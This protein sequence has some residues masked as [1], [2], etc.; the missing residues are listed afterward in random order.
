MG[1][2]DDLEQEA[3]RRKAT[4]GDAERVKLER[5]EAFKT[6]LE[7]GLQA[8]HE[9]L[10][11]L[12]AN[13]SFLKPKTQVRFDF[14]GYGTVVAN[15]EH[16][17]DLRANTI[18]PLSKE[19]VLLFSA[20]V[21]TDECPV[22]QVNSPAKIRTLNSFFQKARLSGIAEFKKDESGEVTQA[23]FRARG[24]VTLN[25]TVAADAESGVAR[26]SFTNFDTLGTVT[27]S[28]AP[29]HFDEKLFDEVGRF[30]ARE[31]NTL[32]RE[33]LPEDF[34]KQLAQK[35]QQEQLKRKWESKIA[36]QQAQDMERAQRA[37]REQSL[38]GKIDRA[39]AGV[40]EKAPS[41]LDKVK[42]LFNKKS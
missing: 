40:A 38:K 7:P 30:I 35:V 34:R 31:T 22:V 42:G 32:F 18:T 8:F 33:Q 10:A 17:Y 9:Y 29:Q 37:Q 20:S 15:I 41:I 11:K 1:L 19:V 2:L 39:V 23:T 27:K 28:A 25:V 12:T 24:K 6:R 26:L 16:E 4:L 3:Q 14:P 21:A 5:E 13:L 36:E